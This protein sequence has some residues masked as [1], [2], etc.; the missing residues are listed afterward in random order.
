MVCDQSISA[1]SLSMTARLTAQIL[2][3]WGFSTSQAAKSFVYHLASKW[4]IFT[5]NRKRCIQYDYR[6]TDGDLFSFVG[7]GNILDACCVEEMLE[8]CR[9]T[10]DEWLNR[11][12]K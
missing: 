7:Y 3:G 5:S 11:K 1:V 9:E 8:A 6:H 10:R 2:S 12:E 4:E